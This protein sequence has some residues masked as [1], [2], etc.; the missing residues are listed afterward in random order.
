MK[1]V[2][3]FIHYSSHIRSP[4]STRSFTNLVVKSVGWIRRQLDIPHQQQRRTSYNNEHEN[5][6]VDLLDFNHGQ[7]NIS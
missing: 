4:G 7:C 5:A 6:R 1:P 3:S 2:S